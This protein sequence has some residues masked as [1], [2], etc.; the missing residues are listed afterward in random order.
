MAQP[1]R[2]PRR[3]ALVGRSGRGRG[4]PGSGR[5]R[6]LHCPAETRGSR[7][8]RG[9]TCSSPPSRWL[10]PGRERALPRSCARSSAPQPG[11]R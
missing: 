4:W 1:T 10:L 8:C 6:F 11:A 9:R 2:P 5:P 7:A 3:R